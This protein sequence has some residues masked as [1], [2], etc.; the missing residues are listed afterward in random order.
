M[1]N[2]EGYLQALKE[3]LEGYSESL[4]KLRDDVGQKN[5]PNYKES[6]QSLQN[7]LKEA[8]KSYE[9]LKSASEKDWEQLKRS[10]AEIFENLKNAFAEASGL[11][12]DQFKNSGQDI[13]DS[14]QDTFDALQQY[15]K[16]NPVKSASAALAIGFILGKIFKWR[17]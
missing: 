1:D 12:L 5:G 17:P 2:R 7:I 16:D 8:V 14:M 15:I 4:K 6:V 11:T 13:A 10:T 3:Q 9:D